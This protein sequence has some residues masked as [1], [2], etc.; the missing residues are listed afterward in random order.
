MIL[1]KKLIVTDKLL[2]DKLSKKYPKFIENN[3]L[4]IPIESISRGSRIVVDVVCDYCGDRSKTP[5]RDYLINI[6]KIDKYACG[7]G[8][9][10]SLKRKDSI[11]SKYGSYD[12]Y[13][14][15]SKQKSIEQY[16]VENRSQLE[17]FKEKRKQTNL[18]K[19]GHVC[20]LHSSEI[21]AK[22]VATNLEKYGAE[23]IRL[24]ERFRKK[25]FTVAKHPNYIEYNQDTQLNRFRCDC[26]KEHEFEITTSLFH[27]RSEKL[28]T[29]CYP[30]GEH[31]SIKETE[32]RKHMESVTNIIPNYRDKYNKKEIDILLE[33]RKTGIEFNGLYWHSEK[34]KEKNYH[35]D[36]QNYFSDRG[37][38][39]VY[40]WE[41]DWDLKKDILKSQ[42]NNSL[43][44]SEKIYGRKTLIKEITRAEAIKFLDNNHLQGSYL[45]ILKAYGL[46]HKETLVSV[47]TFDHQEGRKK[48]NDNEWNLSRF[49]NILNTTV[50][51]GASK[52]L[53]HFIKN[54]TVTRVISYADADW[55]IGGL[56]ETL[57]FSK[58]SHS[59]PDYKYLVNGKREHKSKWRKKP[60]E[61]KTESEIA[62]ERGALKIYDCG[63]I[64][65]EKIIT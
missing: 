25:N 34:F 1:Y 31:S 47:M 26:E 59:K 17:E 54:N 38:R 65:Y 7:K 12:E 23:H 48:M 29:V 36:K 21:K 8:Q 30:I 10:K 32:F 3:V 20:S 6:K 42:I 24:S 15:V 55:S 45:R 33:D 43:G 58:V 5:Y 63:K 41:D 51:G 14:K 18:K 60:G 22:V 57:G 62:K 13:H 27:S 4:T 44:R 37:I 40:I 53:Q 64:K 11:D 39:V 9:C 19:F 52:L 49:C 56:Y 50:V 2:F 46:Y 16:G 35:L 28:C 61:I